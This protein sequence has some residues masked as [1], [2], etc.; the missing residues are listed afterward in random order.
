MPKSPKFY[1]DPITLHDIPENELELREYVID[2]QTQLMSATDI[3]KQVSLLGEIGV[4]FRSLGELE[5]AEASLQ[6]AL[7]LIN[8]HRLG[9]RR[10]VQQM[11]RLA[12]VFQWQKKFKKSDELF[13]QTLAICQQQSEAG[14]YLDFAYQHMGK[15]F[16]DQQR[17]AEAI[18]CFE[19]ALQ[20]RIG[21]KAP[22]DQI[23]SSR[24]SLATAKSRLLN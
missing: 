15:N 2:L 8:T 19:N 9:I 14:V 21:K 16:F 20:I 17:W 24:Q 5:Q 6:K 18:H 22:E 13:Q 4:Y 1:Y 11:L 12:H 23:E 7:D 10:Q 3:E